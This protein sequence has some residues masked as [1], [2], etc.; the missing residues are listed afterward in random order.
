MLAKFSKKMLVAG[1]LSALSLSASAAVY[2][3]NVSAISVGSHTYAYDFTIN[4]GEV[5]SLT[6]K[7]DSF[8]R[9]NGAN[10][11]SGF[12]ITDILLSAGTL[13]KSDSESVTPLVGA[14]TLTADSFTFLNS[15]LA[16]GTYTL[17]VLGTSYS[18]N[19]SFT[20]GFEVVTSPVP[21]PQT[22]GMIALGLGLIGLISLRKKQ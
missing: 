11:V 5:G 2:P 4:A 22:T 9:S 3:I 8:F 13:T 14:R 15:S 19:A 7:I 1:V 21:E 20:G 10:K 16:A 18:S 6:G 12:D 17:T